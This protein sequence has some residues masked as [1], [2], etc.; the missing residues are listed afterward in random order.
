LGEPSVR[1]TPRQ[2]E[3]KAV[4]HILEHEEYPS[5]ED[6]AKAVL[7]TVVDELAKRESRA[8]L[9]KYPQDDTG[10]VYGPYYHEG[11]VKKAV[12]KAREAG[13]ETRSGLLCMP[14][15]WHAPEALETACTCGHQK[16]QH[17]VKKLR[18]KDA[19]GPPQECGVLINRVK[20]SCTNYNVER[21]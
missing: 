1:F 16:E 15:R 19:M 8:I 7:Q 10:L 5:F 13:L 6:M 18:G 17:V 20:C 2:N 21:K 3:V 9:A 4:A 12:E 14:G 11:D